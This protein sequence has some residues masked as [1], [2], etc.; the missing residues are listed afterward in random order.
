MEGAE[1]R[2]VQEIIDYST[3]YQEAA[4][5]SIGPKKLSSAPW[6]NCEFPPIDKSLP[7]DCKVLHV[8][9]PMGLHFLLGAFNDIFDILEDILNAFKSQMRAEDWSKALGIGRNDHYG[10]KKQFNGP[11]IHKMLRN[12]DRLKTILDDYDMLDNCKFIVNAFE[13]FYA[14]VRSCFGNVW[15]QER[16]EGDIQEF[17]KAFFLLMKN[18]DEITADRKLSKKVKANVTPKVKCK[19][20]V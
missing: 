20:K 8:L 17:A 14:M 7:G 19:N 10:A 4:A 6:F 2:S 18:C 16:Y 12:I 15:Y 3:Q 13:A 9:P 1:L 5:E 11:Q